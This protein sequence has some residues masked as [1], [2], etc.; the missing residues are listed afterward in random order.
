MEFS[1]PDVF[2]YG[3]I[4]YIATPTAT[5]GHLDKKAASIAP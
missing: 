3:K 1:T 5:S 4:L 2:G